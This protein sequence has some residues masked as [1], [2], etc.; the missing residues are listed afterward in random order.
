[1]STTLSPPS[2]IEIEERTITDAKGGPK[3]NPPTQSFT[4]LDKVIS[5]RYLG[6]ILDNKL[7]INEHVDTLTK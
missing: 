5:D 2:H 6:V 4:P 3:V 1:M 7:S